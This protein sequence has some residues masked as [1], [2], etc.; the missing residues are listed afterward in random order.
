MIGWKSLFIVVY[1]HTLGDLGLSDFLAHSLDDDRALLP[2]LVCAYFG[3]RFVRCFITGGAVDRRRAVQVL[4]HFCAWK[5]LL[6]GHGSCE[7]RFEQLSR[8]VCLS[9]TDWRRR[10][11]CGLAVFTCD[12]NF[13][14]MIKS[15][16]SK[17][18]LVLSL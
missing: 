8:L 16:F 13:R 7:L 1:P 12:Q 6:D 2:L 15:M 4:V 18:D 5:G 10:G 17:T 3:R 9:I 11:F 14:L